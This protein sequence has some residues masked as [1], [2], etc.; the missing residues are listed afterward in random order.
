MAPSFLSHFS[1]SKLVVEQVV[2][3]GKTLGDFFEAPS[4]SS[5]QA[6]SLMNL[7][8]STPLINQEKSVYI[9]TYGCQMNVSDS[10][11]VRSILLGSGFVIEEEDP[12]KADVILL[13]TC[14]I[15]ENAESKVWDKLKSLRAMRRK[16]RS[17]WKASSLASSGGEENTSVQPVSHTVPPS[18]RGTTWL[19]G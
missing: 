17:S 4:S 16:L 3:D 14:A 15:R 1:S 8:A 12:E 18:S 6:A 2:N 11:I 13:N 10:E 9:K 7:P 19:H 5:V